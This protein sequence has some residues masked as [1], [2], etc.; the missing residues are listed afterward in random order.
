M[1]WERDAYRAVHY[2]KAE[3]KARETDED[4]RMTSPMR[5]TRVTLYIPASAEKG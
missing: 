4:Q 2:T 1:Y 5:R 3:G